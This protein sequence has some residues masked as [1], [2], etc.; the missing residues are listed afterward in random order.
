MEHNVVQGGV[1][2]GGAA[3]QGAP[4]GGGQGGFDARRGFCWNKWARR[5]LFSINSIGPQLM[6]WGIIPSRKFKWGDLN[7]N[8][9]LLESPY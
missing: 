9:E 6:L 8:R 2:R 4:R 5:N 3:D 7:L 1:Q